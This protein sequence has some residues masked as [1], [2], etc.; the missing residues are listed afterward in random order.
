MVSRL[1]PVLLAVGMFLIPAYASVQ[2]DNAIPEELITQAEN[3][4]ASAQYLLGVR[5]SPSEHFGQN[6]LRN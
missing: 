1:A 3:G 4:D 6:P 2:E 5:C